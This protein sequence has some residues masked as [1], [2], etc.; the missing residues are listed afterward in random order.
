MPQVIRSAITHL[1]ICPG[2]VIVRWGK[3][4]IVYFVLMSTAAADTYEL[5]RLCLVC[6]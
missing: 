3:V 4:S 6:D 5:V 1:N 2:I